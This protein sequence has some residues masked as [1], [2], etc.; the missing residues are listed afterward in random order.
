MKNLFE[1]PFEFWS[2]SEIGLF[3]KLTLTFTVLFQGI[4]LGAFSI[5]LTIIYVPLYL[6]DPSTIAG[7]GLMIALVLL[8]I[9][10][11][12]FLKGVKYKNP[13][14]II[15]S[16]IFQ[17]LSFMIITTSANIGTSIGIF[18]GAILGI[19]QVILENKFRKLMLKKESV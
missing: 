4:F 10:A 5:I 15:S 6:L 17:A 1:N 19:P 16:F 18:Y 8:F 14:Y 3:S 7:F 9:H 11:I 2:L 12:C 13:N